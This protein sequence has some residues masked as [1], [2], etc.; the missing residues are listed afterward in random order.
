ML[1]KRVV[2][3]LSGLRRSCDP[4]TLLF[5]HLLITTISDPVK[6]GWVSREGEEGEDQNLVYSH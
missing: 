3:T 2:L 6:H 5:V 1:M 4:V